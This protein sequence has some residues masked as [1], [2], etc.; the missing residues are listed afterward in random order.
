MKVYQYAAD[1][2]KNPDFKVVGE[3]RDAEL[4]EVSVRALGFEE[5]TRY[6]DICKRAEELGLE[7]CPAEVGPQLRLQY[8]DQPTGEWLN[9]AMNA[10]NGS[11]GNPNMFD[12]NRNDDGLWLDS[13]DGRPAYEWNP[14][15]R[16]VFL[17]P[18]R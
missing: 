16:F 6:K 5:W 12:V 15:Y 18:R 2:L 7:L 3:H 8:K 17:C 13:D 1:M 10:I 4:V 11:D 14:E 9:V